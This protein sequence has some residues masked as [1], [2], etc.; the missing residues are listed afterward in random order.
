MSKYIYFLVLITF[1]GSCKNSNEKKTIN[2]ESIITDELQKINLEEDKYLILF[3]S[4]GMCPECI[5]KEFIN[6]KQSA[7]ISNYLI[8]CGMFSNKRYFY[9]SINSINVKHAAYINEDI[10]VEHIEQNNMP[11]YSIYDTKSHH[12]S[13]IMYPEPCDSSK[14]IEYYKGF[15]KH[16]Q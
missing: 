10:I 12:L 5:N 15:M 3:I 7:W 4:E 11:F 8:V 6:I 1:I 13:Q 14:T 16:Y 2:V 9:S